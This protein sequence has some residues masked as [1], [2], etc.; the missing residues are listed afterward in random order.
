MEEENTKDLSPTEVLIDCMEKFGVCEPKKVLVL[1]LD[2]NN[3]LRWESNGL[4]DHEKIGMMEMVKYAL[5]R[6]VFQQP[7]DRKS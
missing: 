3:L 1:T 4:L 6:G 5:M 2:E 7:E